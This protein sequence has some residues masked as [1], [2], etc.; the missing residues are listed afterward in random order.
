MASAG[1]SILGKRG[2][3]DFR[4]TAT[5]YKH[6]GPS[7]ADPRTAD[8]AGSVHEDD[9]YWRYGF[10][11][12]A[13]LAATDTL[14]VQIT[15]FWQD[16]DSDTDGSFTDDIGH[17]RKKEYAAAAQVNY[18]SRDRRFKADASL[19]RY[20]ARRRYFG[21]WYAPEGDPN[22]GVMDSANLNLGY[23]GGVWSLAAGA[24]WQREKSDQTI[25]YSGDFQAEIETRSIYGELALRP[26]EH[27]TIT[28]AARIDD[29]NR[30]GAF[31]TY[32]GTIAYLVPGFT[33]AGSLKLRASYGTGA[34]AP[35]LYQLFDLQYGNPDL[36][37]ETSRG[38]DIG[39][40]LAF[41][42]FTAP[43]LL[44]LRPDEE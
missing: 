5:G 41:D 18:L 7:L 11:G 37:A 9:G 25:Y 16:S 10:S 29:N 24:A 17:V 21:E 2:P 8:P 30:F 22:R 32:R 34:K 20:E 36:K 35:G 12:R 27:L 33:G 13:G 14:S 1:A 26:I 43:A 15:G 44:F 4:V 42:R 31:D 40:D 3:L 39:V 38:G 6:D 19:G 23:N 28:G